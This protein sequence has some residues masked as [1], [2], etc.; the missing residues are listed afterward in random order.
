MRRELILIPI[1]LLIAGGLY[2]LLMGET[3]TTIQHRNLEKEGAKEKALPDTIL[4]AADYEF[5][6]SEGH[7]EV[8]WLYREP[9]KDSWTSRTDLHKVDVPL[10]TSGKFEIK[11]LRN[12][13]EIAYAE[14]YVKVAGTPTAETADAAP[15]QDTLVE[16]VEPEVAE[17]VKPEPK[18]PPKGR[19]RDRDGDGVA[20]AKDD[21]PDDRKEWRD[22]DGDGLGDN[23]DKFPLD[24]KEWYDQDYDG[25]G[26]NSDPDI[27]GDGVA[28]ELDFRPYNGKV[29]AAPGE[30]T[31]D[32]E[33]DLENE[34]AGA[35]A[36]TSGT[37]SGSETDTGEVT[38][39]DSTSTDGDGENE[40]GPTTPPPPEMG[41][42]EPF[43]GGEALKAGMPAPI[44]SQI[45]FTEDICTATVTPIKDVVF[46]G[47]EYWSAPAVDGELHQCRVTIE[48]TTCKSPPFSFPQKFQTP[49]NNAST[50]FF[51]AS[52]LKVTLFA[53]HIYTITL[54]PLNTE[55][56]TF[57]IYNDSNGRSFATD[58][59]EV[60][61]TSN[62]ASMFNF[63][64]SSRP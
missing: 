40:G 19:E 39:T 62:T 16:E 18:S 20:D 60:T 22:S 47:F 17:E 25:I 33:E 1:V 37:N 54:K 3:E 14:T 41:F 8:D 26:N 13:R 23:S 15:E 64:F 34:A 42:A 46:E 11:A 9:G 57:R 27:D 59:V 24:P 38:E 29:W 63:A 36:N 12:N 5:T 45:D 61:Y 4:V 32:E 52:Q 58:A 21:F 55:I 2:F 31:S 28:N 7:D 50:E 48:C 35:D 44:R 56:G 30:A 43:E 49:Q 51:T 10:N 53:G 6:L